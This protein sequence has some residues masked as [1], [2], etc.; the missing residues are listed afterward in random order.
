MEFV[1]F[2]LLIV[3]LGALLAITLG[4]GAVA[5]GG[6]R[7]SERN[8]RETGEET[9]AKID[10]ATQSHKQQSFDYLYSKHQQTTEEALRE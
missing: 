4:A 8:I 2:L 3:F 6:D 10:T 1:V 9:R 7:P 5:S